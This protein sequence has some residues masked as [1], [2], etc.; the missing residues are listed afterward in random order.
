MADREV[1][2]DALRARL[3]QVAVTRDLTPVLEQAAL[4]EA[5]ELAGSLSMDAPD[6]E[7]LFVL[8]WGAAGRPP[9]SARRA[10]TWSASC[11]R[12]LC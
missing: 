12:T 3:E 10:S 1:L 11:S 9:R 2:L 6:M 5:E 7:A 4:A 8:G